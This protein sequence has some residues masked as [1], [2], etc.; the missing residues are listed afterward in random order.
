MNLY[1]IVF[2]HTAP[3][4]TEKGIKC[5]LLA[6]NDEAVYEWIASDPELAK[7]N[8]IF[9]SWK[10]N[11]TYTYD[12]DLD[13]W[14]DEDG[15][16]TGNYWTDE[17]GSPEPFKNRMLRLKGEINDEDYDFTD[18]YYGITLYGWELLKENAIESDYSE[19]IELGIV[20]KTK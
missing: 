12:D 19:L 6:E 3:K 8:S 10:D 13:E 7:F 16:D 4:D 11:E 15:D 17:K 1:K 2:S 9:T 18:A 20:F 14:I 5:L